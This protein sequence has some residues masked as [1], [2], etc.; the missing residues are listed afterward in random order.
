MDYY[1]TKERVGALWYNK[2]WLSIVIVLM[3]M[4]KAFVVFAIACIALVGCKK[5]GPGDIGY[6]VQPNNNLDSMVSFSA[7]V[8][9][10]S[11]HTDSVYAYRVKYGGDSGRSDLYI[12]AT[13][14]A[15]D[16]ISTIALTILN[17]TGPNTYNINPPQNT[18]SY[19]LGHIRH[20]GIS[21]KIIITTDS[22]YAIT[23]TADFLADS[24]HITE[25]VFN[26]AR[27]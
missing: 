10:G 14:K 19:Y 6:S 25:G 26:V 17:Y 18:A 16:T 12:S 2:E 1:Y 15:N 11:W 4:N 21:G 5:K 3:H 9:G 13:Q 20:Y 24:T 8:N 22:N 23:G 7:K 27:P